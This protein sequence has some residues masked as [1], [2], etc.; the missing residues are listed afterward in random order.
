M[1]TLDVL[2][3]KLAGADSSSSSAVDETANKDTDTVLNTMT[4]PVFVEKL[5]SAVD[6]IV[7]QLDPSADPQKTEEVDETKQA[8]V[9]EAYTQHI[10]D[11]A[12][13][14]DTEGVSRISNVLKSRL[15]AKQQDN[16]K[17]AAAATSNDA[18]ELAKTVLGK[19]SKL[20]PNVADEETITETKEASPMEEAPL[21]E[22]F[23]TENYEHEETDVLNKTEGQE[24]V[25]AASV[26]QTL[27]DVLNA[28]LSS[29]EQ[30]DAS[31]QSE[32]AKTAGV[33]GGS[34]LTARKQGVET[35]KE[36]LLTTV[37]KEAQ[38]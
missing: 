26:D 21:E 27:A 1:S 31:V 4:D 25:K 22:V 30:S 32:D 3:Q 15:L 36:K 33:R 35:L 23:G 37:G 12:A 9:P 38:S 24:E 16:E 17:K 6:F 14:Q 2:I 20:R 8:S 10:I 29:N 11:I 5:A 18:A 7:D 13:S 28:A 34:G 19:L